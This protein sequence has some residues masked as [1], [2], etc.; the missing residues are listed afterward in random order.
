M[1]RILLIALLF[2]GG[3]S[4]A[5]GQKYGHLNFGNMLSLMPQTKTADEQLEAFQKGLVAKG[6]QM[7]VEFKGNVAKYIAESQTG[8]MSPK[9]QQERQ[10]ALQ[11]EQDAIKAYEED[12]ARQVEAKREELLKP[13]VE[14]LEKTI[15]EVAKENG[16]TLVFDTGTFNAI[17]HARDTDDLMP[18]V[19][20]KL[21][22]L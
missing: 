11:K 9:I 18:L 19:K 6:E 20:K 16:F 14:T 10:A 21:G 7:A 3:L 12:V 5:H 15:Q 1:K 4:A 22:I 2:A 17:L 8:T 13:I